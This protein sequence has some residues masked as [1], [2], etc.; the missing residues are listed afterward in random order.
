MSI[1]GG[2]DLD[3]DGFADYAFAGLAT[4]GEP[5][6]PAPEGAPRRFAIGIEF[7]ADADSEERRSSGI[8]PLENVSVPT[9]VSAAGDFDGDGYGDLLYAEPHNLVLARG[10]GK[11]PLNL[12]P[13]ARLDAPTL[14][15]VAAGI[16]VNGDGFT[17]VVHRLDTSEGKRNLSLVTG[18]RD[19]AFGGPTTL[20]PQID[21]TQQ[22]R[23][24]V[25]GDFDG[26]GL[27]DFALGSQREGGLGSVCVYFGD[28]GGALR[29]GN[30]FSGDRSDL[31][32]GVALGAVD[33]WGEGRDV[34]LVS[35]KDAAGMRIEAV[36]FDG[37]TVT[38]EPVAQGE[39]AAITTL[40]PGHLGKPGRWAATTPELDAVR[41]H[42]GEERVQ[43]L[44]APPGARAFGRAL[45]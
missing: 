22:I 10:S 24:L 3:G 25:S 5:G 39:G 16:D 40:L 45:R 15:P 12:F 37:N 29:P 14:L 21:A 19:L 17:D 30:C 23:A 34:L 2:T 44:P 13:I 38:S 43:T 42:E 11:G 31:D 18:G 36:T 9:T 26:D 28:K 1:T 35:A 8:T 41:I 4:L 32:W 6:K 20:V 33:L 27:S 7:G